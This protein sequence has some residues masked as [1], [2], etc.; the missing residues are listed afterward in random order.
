MATSGTTTAG[1]PV[2]DKIVHGALRMVGAYHAADNPRPEQVNDAVDALDMMLKSWQMDGLLWL[3]QF[4]YVTL[5]A[6][7][8]SYTIGTGSTDTVT[9]D[10]AGLVPFTQRATRIFNPTRRNITTGYEVPLSNVARA[11]WSNIVN[12]SSQGVPV[13]VYYDP[14]IATG[15]LY[16]WPVPSTATDQIVFTVDR[17]IE[18]VGTDENWLDVPPEWVE[19]VKYSLAVRLAVE[20][21]MPG[22]DYD[23][24]FQAA[25]MMKEKMVSNN[26]DNASTFFQPGR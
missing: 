9:T 14:R 11:D 3:K 12:K 10:T 5:V 23:R 15:I 20:Y 18:D 4:V 1:N 7:Q 13:Q 2:R 26:T 17:I 25:A 19:T 22:S 21:A 8:G 6:G 16:V 24:L